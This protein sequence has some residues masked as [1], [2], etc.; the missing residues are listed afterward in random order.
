MALFMT[1]E[2]GLTQHNPGWVG[3]KLLRKL[4]TR[5]VLTFVTETFFYVDFNCAVVKVGRVYFL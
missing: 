1:S 5:F 2:L 3:D 4:Q